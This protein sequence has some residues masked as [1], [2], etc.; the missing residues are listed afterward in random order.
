MRWHV[1]MVALGLI[2]GVPVLEA[3]TPLGTAFTYQGRLTDNSQPAN[4][5]YD[6]RFLLFDAPTGGS[7]LGPQVD[8]AGVSVT[9]GLFTVSLDFGS[10]GPVFTGDARWLEVAVSPAGGGTYTTLMPR[11][12]LTPSPHAVFSSTAPW[13]GISGI[14]AGFADGV[15]N[16][17]TYSAGAGLDLAGTV[18][19]LSDQ[20][21]TTAKLAD[22]SVTSAKIA[23]GAVGLAQIDTAQVQ[24][25]ISGTCAFGSY[26]RGINS[27]G[28]AVCE[29]LPIPPALSIVDDD[30]SHVVAW[31]T[32]IAIGSDGLPAIAYG[33]FTVGAVRLAKCGNT[34]CSAGN[35]VTVVDDPPS[36]S[37]NEVHVSMA[38]GS[39]GLPV[40]SYWIFTAPGLR[41]A[42]CGN[43]ACTSGNT[44]VVVDPGAGAGSSPSIAVGPDGLPVMS[45]SD[46]D[47]GALK[48]AKC[49]NAACTAG[50][51]VVTVDDP[52]SG[53]LVG[54][55]TSLAIAT[56]GR[57]IISYR[58]VTA[59]ALKVAKCGDSGC[60]AGNT[61]T[62]IDGVAGIGGDG[63]FTSLVIGADG[64][65]VIS[66]VVDDES[67]LRVLRCGNALCTAG[68]TISTVDSMAASPSITIGSDGLPVVSYA[69]ITAGAIKV[70]KCA[71]A[72]CA[73]G[74]A[75]VSVASAG[76]FPSIA[77]GSDGLPVISYQDY[78]AQALKVAKC[79][80][81]A[82]R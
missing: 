18:F 49:G 80:N 78:N 30:P 82:C 57:P 76:T 3:Q 33:D 65:P 52:P 35:V 13:A 45:Y 75:T 41:V 1:A 34:G 15:D 66:Y 21:V 22:Q 48:L 61:L 2:S 51:S 72:G 28:T 32:S 79:G 10:Q 16:D 14:P 77:I 38:I 67:A 74:N 63:G 12:E 43:A 4:G 25:R 40:I 68:N 11:Q 20:G 6:L 42:K 31:H 46:Q 58:D 19:S 81:A 23:N 47:A 8:L 70:T 5:P 7:Q 39:D 55:G 37:Q 69:D 62:T 9:G 73:A 53:N 17:T 71:D 44:L 64:R 60:T 36:A 59:G 54:V 27:D 26:V 29:L 56:D 50:N 24:A